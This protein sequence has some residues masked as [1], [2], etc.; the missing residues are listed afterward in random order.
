MKVFLVDAVKA[1]IQS[2]RARF[3]WQRVALAALL[4]VVLFG[5]LVALTGCAS[6]MPPIQGAAGSLEVGA[7]VETP[8]G[9]GH[10]DIGD[11][12]PYVVLQLGGS[13]GE[14]GKVSGA[15]GEWFLRYGAIDATDV[16][17][18][19]LGLFDLSADVVRAGLGLRLGTSR[20]LGMDCSLG[21]GAALTVVNGDADAGTVH[22]DVSE[23]GVGAY[24]QGSA[25]R[26][27]FFL[28]AMYISG[29]T[30]DVDDLDVEL[31]GLSVVG[32]LRWNF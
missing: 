22:R 31:G 30:A 11:V 6:S 26:G 23:S 28:Q 32:G 9:R 1:T 8:S 3:D 20:V 19:D 4:G 7:G 14:P 13:M 12:G 18:G 2:E 10:D 29:P 5:A 24:V 25:A 21:L 15:R 16:D 17:A 27:P